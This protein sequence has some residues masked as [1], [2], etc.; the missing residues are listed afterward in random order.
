VLSLD[1]AIPGT[2]RRLAP[3]IETP[4]WRDRLAEL[5]LVV[6][7]GSRIGTR[8]WWRG[9]ATCTALCLAPILLVP[10]APP[11]VGADRP[12]LGE[13]Q[14]QEARALAISPLASGA[15]TGRRMA[16]N[17]LVLP[18]A[19]TPERPS[20]DLTATLGQGDGF[21][22][23]IERAGVARDEARRVADMVSGVVALEELRSGT[24]LDMTLG[25][26]ASKSQPR[27]LDHMLFRARFDL[28]L[29]IGRTDG[30]LR[31]KRIPIA[32]D[33]T[34]LRI[35]GIVG[36]SLYRSARAAGAPA[37]AVEA[38]IRALGT[39]LSL[40]SIG[41]DATFDLVIEHRKAETGEV[42]VGQ[43]LYAGLTQGNRKTR[44]LRWTKDG[45][46]QFFEASGVGER[47]AGFVQPVTGG[48]MTSGFGMRRHPL[49]GYSRFHK[50][51]DYGAAYG[52]P[53]RAVTEGT[54]SYAGWHGGHGRYVKLNHAGGM[55]TG[56]AHMSR[57]AVA[58]GARVRQGQVIGYVGS[59]GLSTG[60]HLHF[61]VYR[62]GAAV[63]P[64]GVAFQTVSLLAGAELANFR[65]TLA[66]LTAIRPGEKATPASAM[67][68][69]KR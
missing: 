26:R 33:D 56:Y 16:A 58:S 53:I 41:S 30:Q 64:R 7:L 52:T 4:G 54:V 24:R 61:E 63:N 48:R 11:L 68:E 65:A 31:I 57:I 59:T 19:D 67:A 5:D 40:G 38:Y 27:P 25:R 37:K 21:A 62:G 55:A 69:V 12:A 18:L 15:D 36:S 2:G 20:I 8:E 3:A 13:A 35:Q 46:A 50:G 17:D 42:E 51:V 47:T 23:A 9:L 39:R 1:A 14:W 44:L 32:V 66:R 10:D 60:P 28:K 22:R 6:D 29:E 45:K 43:L 34:P 49:L